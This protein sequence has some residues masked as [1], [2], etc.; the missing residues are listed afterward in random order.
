MGGGY[1]NI[2][3]MA[4][5][6]FWGFNILNFNNFGW[7]QKNKYFWGMKKLWIFLGVI[8]KL[9]YFGASIQYILGFFLKVK[10]QNGNIFWGSLNFQISFG[11]C[12][13]RLIFFLVN[14][15]GW[16]QAYVSRIF[17]SIP[18][19][20]LEFCGLHNPLWTQK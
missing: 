8:T 13:I 6:I 20:H 14:I 2:F 1:S 17:E 19:P 9:D 3:I 18:T 15:G 4:R 11:V 5:T 7:F 12:L 10:V 16:F